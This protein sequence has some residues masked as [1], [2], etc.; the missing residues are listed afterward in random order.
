MYVDLYFRSRLRR[1]KPSTPEPNSVEL[2][3]GPYLDINVPR[4]SDTPYEDAQNAQDCQYL[5]PEPNPYCQLTKPKPYYS[6]VTPG[7]S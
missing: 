2:S 6:Y 1:E 5:S 3:Y 7:T 4:E